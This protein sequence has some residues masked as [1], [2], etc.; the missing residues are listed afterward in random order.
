MG[1]DRF[2]KMMQEAGF[3]RLLTVLILTIARQR[4]QD[5]ITGCRRLAKS[6]THFVAVEAR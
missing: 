2:D 6:A 4:D 3:L 5:R 1:L